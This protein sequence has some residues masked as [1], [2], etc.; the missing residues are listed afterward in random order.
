MSEQPPVVSLHIPCAVFFFW[1]PS[2]LLPEKKP[3]AECSRFFSVDF[4]NTAGQTV[5]ASY[6]KETRRTLPSVIQTLKRSFSAHP[7]EF[8]SPLLRL[9]RTLLRRTH[10]RRHR[11]LYNHR[12]RQCHTHTLQDPQGQSRFPQYNP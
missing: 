5:Y 7:N 2:V 9:L 3:T 1:R 12:I 6:E 4:T 11:R 8:I 10:I